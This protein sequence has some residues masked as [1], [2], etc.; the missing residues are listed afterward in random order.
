MLSGH[1]LGGR[2][3]HQ[4]LLKLNIAYIAGVGCAT[5]LILATLSLIMLEMMYPREP[6]LWWIILSSLTIGIGLAVTFFYYRKSKGTELWIP[7]RLATTL[8]SR[9]KKT[10]HSA[11]AFGLGATSVV[12]ELVFAIAPMAVAALY[13][14]RL[15]AH[16]QWISLGAYILITL[17]PLLIITGMVG[18]GHKISTIQ[19]WR[20]RNKH[21]L[22]YTAGSGLIILGLYVL[23][24][25]VVS[26]L[27]LEGATIL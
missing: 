7:R 6:V 1:S 11:E 8:A 26:A 5:L 20:E 16:E 3:A 9:T 2:R 13:M 10:S 24:T 27:A 14:V 23:I 21:F 25:E 19:R 15:N 18:A 12:S 17:L 22:Q 4:T